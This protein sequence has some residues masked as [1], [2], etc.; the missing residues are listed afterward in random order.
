VEK[1]AQNVAQPL[2]CQNY[3]TAFIG[4]TIGILFF[5]TNVIL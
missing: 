3:K 2:F 1:I 4:E 5:A